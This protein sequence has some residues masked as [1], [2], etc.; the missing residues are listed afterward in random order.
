LVYLEGIFLSLI[1]PHWNMWRE[2]RERDIKK[3]QRKRPWLHIEA[4]I[5]TPSILSKRS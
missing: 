3:K 1:S 4:S 2:M 5:T